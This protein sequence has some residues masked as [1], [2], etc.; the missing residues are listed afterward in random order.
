MR[1]KK[2][3]GGEINVENDL[4]VDL[5]FF[6]KRKTSNLEGMS[7]FKVVSFQVVCVVGFLFIFIFF[8]A[9]LLFFVCLLF[10]FFWLCFSWSRIQTVTRY[11]KFLLL[12]L[13]VCILVNGLIRFSGVFFKFVVVFFTGNL[14]K[15]LLLVF[16]LF[17]LLSGV[18]RVRCCRFVAAAMRWQSGLGDYGPRRRRVDNVSLLPQVKCIN[19]VGRATSHSAAR[20]LVR[21]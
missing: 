21:S 17:W 2:K 6:T 10:L 15:C 4:Q 1:E 11:I 19:H 7:C 5:F 8:F 12:D 16:L 14:K 18:A 9:A 13:C 3:K 20:T